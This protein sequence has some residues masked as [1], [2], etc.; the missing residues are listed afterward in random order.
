MEPLSHRGMTALRRVD[1]RGGRSESAPPVLN[2]LREHQGT[3]PDR[4]F[5]KLSSDQA[6]GVGVSAS[7]GG[8][9]NSGSSPAYKVQ[10]HIYNRALARIQGYLPPKAFLLGR[11]WTQTKKG[12]MTRVDSC[13]DQL[14]PV[15]HN[16]VVRGKPLGDHADR[17]VQ[18]LR[19]MRQDG[20]NWDALPAPTLHRRL[21]QCAPCA[22]RRTPDALQRGGWMR[23]SVRNKSG[24]H[25]H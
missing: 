25:R 24:R 15:A 9:S 13:M 17:A 23:C 11:G 19:R 7:G 4:R 22:P 21:E 8:L 12:Q 18:W 14:A 1:G 2:A 5:G 3:A 20:H 6:K 10:L 16:E